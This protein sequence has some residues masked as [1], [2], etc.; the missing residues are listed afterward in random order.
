MRTNP[1]PEDAIF[2]VCTERAVVET[3]SDRPVAADSLEA[4]GRVTWIL[5]QKV[6]IGPREFLNFDRKFR[7]SFP[8]GWRGMVVHNGRV[9][10]AA[11]SA[12][13]CFIKR[14]SFPAFASR[15]I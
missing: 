6:E 1:R 3:D 2:Y 10:P 11:W 13:A 7:E 4:Q 14:S 8:E 5:T 12:S 15:S 9:L